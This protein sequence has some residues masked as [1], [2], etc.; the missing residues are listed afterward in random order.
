M[1][2]LLATNH[3]GLGGSES[4]LLVVGEQ[5]DRLGHEV[6]IYTP[7]GGRGE[8]VAEE[9]ELRLVSEAEFGGFDAALAQ[10]GAVSY[11]I[12]ERCPDVAQA[13]VAHSGIFDLQAPPQLDGAVGAVIVLNDRLEQ[14]LRQY[15]IQP[16]LVR[17]RQP[18]D[19]Q[20]FMPQGPLREVPRKALLLSNTPHD[21]RLRMLEAACAGAGIELGRVGGA[22]G[23]VTDVRSALADVDIVIGYGRSVLEG[24]ACGKAAF[25]Y[26]WSGGDG[27][28]TRESY[29]AIEGDGFA[30]RSGRLVFDADTLAAELGRYSAAMG[31]VN[32]DLVIAHHRAERHAEQLVE[33][34]GEMAPAGRRS[35]ESLREMGRLV[36]LEWRAQLDVHGLRRENTVAVQ[37]LHELERSR[38]ELRVQLEE[39]TA[40]LGE[41]E[42]RGATYVKELQLAYEGT[43]SWRL[44]A[45]LRWL[46]ARLRGLRTR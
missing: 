24:M 18:I 29:E 12:A 17:L 4:Y 44:T 16:P 35:R 26:D 38:E 32:R 7:E 19:T 22:A 46:G 25:V 11:R 10:D 36:R 30:G 28:V 1:R 40:R 21:D 3:L 20:R 23:Q 13:F 27:W 41:A 14:R 31:P 2:L 42:A 34:I 39:T 9:R 37:R 8:A 5:L 43:L 15:S 45:P 6:A 33:L